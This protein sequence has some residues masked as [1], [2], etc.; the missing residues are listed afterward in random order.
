MVGVV[1]L[2]F[3]VVIIT[4]LFTD[5]RFGMRDVGLPYGME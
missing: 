3:G 2:P 1:L 5:V 4:A